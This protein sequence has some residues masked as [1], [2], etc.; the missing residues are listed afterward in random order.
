MLDGLIDRISEMFRG[1]EVSVVATGGNA[2]LIV[3]YCRR[4]VPYEPKLLMEGLL[5]ICHRNQ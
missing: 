1:G 5:H 2:P 4:T 3:R